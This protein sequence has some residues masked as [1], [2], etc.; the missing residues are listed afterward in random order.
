MSPRGTVPVSQWVGTGLDFYLSSAKC[1]EGG[2]LQGHSGLGLSTNQPPMYLA[3]QGLG[4][5]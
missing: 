4:E 3:S 5:E 1:R 2:Q